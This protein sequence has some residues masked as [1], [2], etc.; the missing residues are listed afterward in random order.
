MSTPTDDK[1]PLSD[2]Y[3]VRFGKG[4]NERGEDNDK[5]E[6]SLTPIADEE[7]RRFEEQSNHNHETQ[8]PPEEEEDKEKS[9]SIIEKITED[10]LER[11]KFLTVEESRE[12]LVYDKGVYAKGG[13]V[14]I[15]KTAENLFGYD[16]ANRHL[17]EVKGH[18]M[19]KT[20]HKRESWMRT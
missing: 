4:G 11:F 8:G 7:I 17:A 9:I 20:F 14:L 13:E 18:I 1:D 6:E 16:L 10:I 5:E 15:E 19:R 3:G 12:I 2:L